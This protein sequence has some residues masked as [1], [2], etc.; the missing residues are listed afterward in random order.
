M[1]AILPSGSR[2]GLILSVFFFVLPQ[3]LKR[4]QTIRPQLSKKQQKKKRKRI[5]LLVVAIVLLF[6]VLTV[7]RCV[8]L[9]PNI[10]HYMSENMYSIARVAPAV[11]KLYQYFA[12]PIGV[13]NAYLQ[14]PDFYFGGNTFGPLYNMINKLGGGLQYSRYQKFYDIPI[15]TNVGTWIRELCEDF[16]LIGMFLV[17]LLFSMLVGFFERRTVKYQNR[18]DIIMA[19]VLGTIFVM[20]FFVWYI[21][22]GTMQVIL[23]ACIIMRLLSSV[24]IKN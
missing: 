20:S 19:S 8:Q 5:V 1:L 23:L 11:F 6:V 18:D 3:C 22:E 15:R 21:R 10:Y 7:S 4:K 9:D 16:G 17:V 14:H 2:G 24:T 13:L 12:S